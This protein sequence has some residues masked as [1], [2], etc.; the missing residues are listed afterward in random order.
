MPRLRHGAVV[1]ETAVRRALSSPAVRGA[2]LEQALAEATPV[3]L[4]AFDF[5]FPTLQDDPANLLPES[6]DTPAQLKALGQTMEDVGR[7]EE[8][9]PEDPDAGDSSVAAVYTY[10]GQFVD[11]DITFD[12]VSSLERL[13]D[14]DALVNF[15]TPRFD[16]DSVYGRG[17]LDEPFLYDDNDLGR[18]PAW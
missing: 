11:H 16:L 4:R 6:A 7:P 12:P 5:L 1:T 2:A 18:F 10:F 13:N 9:G 15:R 8:L 17:P 14:P 3:E